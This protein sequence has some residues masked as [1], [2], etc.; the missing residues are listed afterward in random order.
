V[1][2]P[3]LGPARA[4]FTSFEA[5]FGA[6]FRPFYDAAAQTVDLWRLTRSQLESAGLAP[7]RI[8]GLDQCTLSSPQDFFSYRAARVTGRQMALI[9]IDAPEK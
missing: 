9:W 8:F 7:R 4:Q 6:D 1:R 5:E 3:S 2:G